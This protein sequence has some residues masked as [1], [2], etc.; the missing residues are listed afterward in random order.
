VDDRAYARNN[1]EIQGN[2]Q[3]IS[4]PAGEQ[5]DAVLNGDR[6]SQLAQEQYESVQ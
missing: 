3:E 5:L 4:E 1:R 2:A 6:E